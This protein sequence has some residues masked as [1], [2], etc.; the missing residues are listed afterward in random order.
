MVLINLKCNFPFKICC[1]L[2]YKNLFQI[3]CIWFMIICIF[4]YFQI[5][6]IPAT[7]HYFSCGKNLLLFWLRFLKKKIFFSGLRSCYHKQANRKKLILPLK[8]YFETCQ[9]IT[10][11]VINVFSKW[12]R[13]CCWNMGIWGYQQGIF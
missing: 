10:S 2:S 8:K 7:N 13:Y 4:H 3:L 5:R 1:T 6:Q 12:V 11:W 9:Y